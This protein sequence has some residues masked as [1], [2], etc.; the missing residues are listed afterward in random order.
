MLHGLT[1]WAFTSGAQRVVIDTAIGNPASQRGI[2][3]A[4][5]H[6]IERT[7]SLV[8]GHRLI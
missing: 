2:E 3:R 7:T 1:R 4:G 5:F 8:V 6:E